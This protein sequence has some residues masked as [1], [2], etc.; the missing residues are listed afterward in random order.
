M[1]QLDLGADRFRVELADGGFTAARGTA[2]RPDATTDTDPDTFDAVMWGNRSLADAQRAGQLRV[3]EDRAA[4]ERL[5][6][7]FPLPEPAAPAGAGV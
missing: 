2:E 7:L 3:A 5:V 1:F 6:G 4:V